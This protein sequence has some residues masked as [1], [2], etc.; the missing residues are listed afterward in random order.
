MP[1]DLTDVSTSAKR[2]R[3][4]YE[5]LRDNPFENFGSAGPITETDIHHWVATINGPENSPYEGGVFSLEID[6]PDKYPFRP[7]V[8]RF[9]TKIFHPNVNLD[10]DICV[11]TIDRMWNPAVVVPNLVMAVH[12]MLADP[13]RGYS[14]NIDV[15]KMYKSDRENFNMV[16]REWTRMYAQGE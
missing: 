11:D 8:I 14:T 16:A 6:F 4:E 3:K 1:L 2:L 10:G 15:T 5:H 7:P 13:Y 9:T 12:S